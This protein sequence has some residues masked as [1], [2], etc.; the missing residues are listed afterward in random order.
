MLSLARTRYPARSVSEVATTI[1]RY[2]GRGRKEEGTLQPSILLGDMVEAEGAHDAYGS[3]VVGGPEAARGHIAFVLDGVVA[4]GRREICGAASISQSFSAD[5]RGGRTLDHDGI[6]SMCRGVWYTG[7]CGFVAGGCE[8]KG[9]PDAVVMGALF[10][11]WNVS[12]PQPQYD[13]RD[14]GV[15]GFGTGSVGRGCGFGFGCSAPAA[16]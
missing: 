2:P 14:G 13:R 8:E 5:I 3:E 6:A 15:N 12:L 10:R 16:H 9:Y 7:G 11:G 4:A 1:D